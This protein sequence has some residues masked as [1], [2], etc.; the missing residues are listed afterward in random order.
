M[1]L[2]LS[3]IVMVI[4]VVAAATAADVAPQAKNVVVKKGGPSTYLNVWYYSS[5][6]TTCT[7]AV[8]FA[9]SFANNACWNVC[10]LRRSLAETKGASQG[11]KLSGLM[12]RVMKRSQAD[13]K[14]AAGSF[15]PITQRLSFVPTDLGSIDGVTIS[16]TG[17]NDSTCDTWNK[18]VATL[19]FDFESTVLPLNTCLG[20]GA[21][22]RFVVTL[23]ARPAVP[24]YAVTHFYSIR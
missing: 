15:T 24:A 3:L 17:Y 7:G 11:A 16:Y 18:D 14:L 8:G 6:D 13:A 23:S 5:A 9:G 21:D 20:T 4:V 19:D 22:P 10:P 2:F 12:N 1:Q